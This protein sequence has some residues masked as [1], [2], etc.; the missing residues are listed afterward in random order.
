M[1]DIV[2]QNTR[3]LNGICEVHPWHL[4]G[5]VFLPISS[6]RGKYPEGEIELGHVPRDTIGVYGSDGE[7]ECGWTRIRFKADNV[8]VWAIHCHIVGHYAMGMG[9]IIVVE[10]SVL[11]VSGGSIKSKYLGLIL[12]LVMWVI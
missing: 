4:H 1:V 2:F 6:G 11:A 12:A 8:G 7:D 9:G 10:D 3:A 5:H